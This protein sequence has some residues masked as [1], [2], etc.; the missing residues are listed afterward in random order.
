MQVTGVEINELNKVLESKEE[1]Q[2]AFVSI[3]FVKRIPQYLI[4][5]EL[6]KNT[7]ANAL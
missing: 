3:N 5:Y 1:E 7:R 4:M 2:S 6:Q